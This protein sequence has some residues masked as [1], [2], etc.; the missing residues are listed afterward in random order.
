MNIMTA[1][2]DVRDVIEVADLK[3]IWQHLEKVFGLDVKVY[4]EQYERYVLTCSGD[5]AGFVDFGAAEIEPILNRMIGRD[6]SYPTWNNLLRFLLKDK[7]AENSEQ[8]R[9]YRSGAWKSFTP[10]PTAKGRGLS[11]VIFNPSDFLILLQG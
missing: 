8:L 2:K 4:Q 5:V 11:A 6:S 1:Q 9:Y 7:L 10:I 3:I